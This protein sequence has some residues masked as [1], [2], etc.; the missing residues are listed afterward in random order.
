[1]T[2]TELPFQMFPAKRGYFKTSVGKLAECSDAEDV[3]VKQKH[4]VL[5]VFSVFTEMD[6]FV[7][8]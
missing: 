5:V 1:M 3:V 8:M 6:V 2:C 7:G 4:N